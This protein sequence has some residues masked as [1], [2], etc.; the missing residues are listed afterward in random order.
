MGSNSFDGGIEE[1]IS[2]GIGAR[3]QFKTGNRITADQI[4]LKGFNEF[5]AAQKAPELALV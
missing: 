3:G 4:T 2:S 1:G 5:M